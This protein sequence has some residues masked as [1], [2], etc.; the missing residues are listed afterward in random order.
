MS[1]EGLGTEEGKEGLVFIWEG[2]AGVI[3][4]GENE[5]VTFPHLLCMLARVVVGDSQ[6]RT[7]VGC[8]QFWPRPR[9]CNLPVASPCPRKC[10]PC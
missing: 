4:S 9:L 5:S 2:T 8:K 1:R 7:G 10:E 3:S 6:L